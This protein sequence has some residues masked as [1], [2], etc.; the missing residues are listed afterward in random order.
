VHNSE[1]RFGTDTD[2]EDQ[3]NAVFDEMLQIQAAIIQGLGLHAEILEMPSTDLGAA[4][5]RKVDIEAFFPSRTSINGGY[6]ELTSASNC[7]DHQSRRL[8]T[9]LKLAGGGKLAFPYTL[10][11]TAL[12]VP[13]V[14]ACLLENGWDESSRTVSI[15]FCLR[16]W[17]PGQIERIGPKKKD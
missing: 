11:G 4:A 1:D 6:G 17:M 9:R 16:K 8:A 7:T 5:A 3:S 2:D 12:A 14:L 15:P 13:R 10:N